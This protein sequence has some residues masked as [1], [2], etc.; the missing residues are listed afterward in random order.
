MLAI[1]QNNPVERQKISDL[2]CMWNIKKHSKETN[3]TKTKQTLGI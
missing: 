1:K 3:K 2:T